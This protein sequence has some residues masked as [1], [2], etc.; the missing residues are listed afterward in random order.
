MLSSGHAHP[1][2]DDTLDVFVRQR[3]LRAL[4]LDRLVVTLSCTSS[5]GVGEER[6]VRL[7]HRRTAM[8]L[9]NARL[10]RGARI[11]AQLSLPIEGAPGT[12]VAVAWSVSLHVRLLNGPDYRCTYPVRVR[13]PVPPSAE[14][15]ADTQ[16]R[17]PQLRA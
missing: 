3:A 2:L 4:S 15:A 17:S 1:R 8:A 16:V 13:P 11:Q 6:R 9:R 5:E 10:P 14:A 7:L 12:S